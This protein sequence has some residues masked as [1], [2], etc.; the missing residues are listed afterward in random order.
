MHPRVVIAGTGSGTGK[1]TVSIGLMAA[2]K[3]KGLTVQ[4]FKCGPD[5]IDPSYHTAV[6]DRT[7]RNLD[8][9]MLDEP[10]VQRVF[11]QGANDAD[12]SVIEGVMGMYDGKSPES[13]RGSTAEISKLLQAPV[14]LVVNIGAMA[15]SAA[16]I[17]KGFQLLSQDT[18]VG[19]VIVNQ[20]GSEGHAKLCQTAIE[21]ECGVPV[22]GYLKKGDVEAIPE[23]HLGL[24]P[25]IERG[26]LD[27]FFGSLTT[28]VETQV[29]IEKI[30]EIAKSAP[31]LAMP[32]ITPK[33]TEKI[34]NIA[35]AYDAAFNFYYRENLEMLEENGA[36]LLYFSPL[37]G[38]VLPENSHA[39]YIGGGFPEEFAEQLEQQAAVKAS[40]KQAKEAGLP[41]Y[42]ECGGYM[43][44]METLV[45]TKNTR[46][47]MI[48][49]IPAEAAMQSSLAALG[50]RTITALEDTT[51]LK[52]GDTAKGH[53]FHYSMTRPAY[54][55]KQAYQ[56]QT[57][58]KTEK[59][60]YVRHNV[61]A[62]YS[63]IHFGTN[64][65]IAKRFV[66]QA[67]LWKKNREESL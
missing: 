43:Y 63:H 45:T 12:I 3:R 21:K 6:T 10:M 27:S 5:Y 14:I 51:I 42:A 60:G 23:R 4:G 25:A 46:H 47:E 36:R 24:I 16:A 28:A 19:G 18:T 8:S 67:A 15:R 39:L 64:P 13:D 49:I 52:A 26:E 38:D 58:R 29:D 20:A 41:I 62:G 33:R 31:E 11:Q 65:G 34:V 66:E 7:S 37:A 2:L 22:V 50:Y 44:L 57:L 55:W 54:E 59:E 30:Q 53:E 1:T 40:I 56:V 61:T 9:W 32:S 17:V 35:V 48:G